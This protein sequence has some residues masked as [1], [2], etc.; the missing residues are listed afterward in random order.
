M[1][2]INDVLYLT[3]CSS[4]DNGAMEDKTKEMYYLTTKK[5]LQKSKKL[6]KFELI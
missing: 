4:S 3:A 5:S 6:S 1:I 2:P